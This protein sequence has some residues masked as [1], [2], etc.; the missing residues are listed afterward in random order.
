MYIRRFSKIFAI[1]CSGSQLCSRSW[2]SFKMSLT[3]GK[4]WKVFNRVIESHH[5]TST[6]EI[7]MSHW[8]AGDSIQFLCVPLVIVHSL[9]SRTCNRVYLVFTNDKILFFW[10]PDF[11]FYSCDS[12]HNIFN[13]MT[14]TATCH[15][16]H[17]LGI[18][19]TLVYTQCWYGGVKKFK[20][21]LCWQCCLSIYDC[22]LGQ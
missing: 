2:G 9:T 22:P 19:E 1:C 16:C 11:W 12:I 21:R 18:V 10:N 14:L 17:T 4:F 15:F 7:F 20:L 13:C 3:F 5:R 6:S 8:F